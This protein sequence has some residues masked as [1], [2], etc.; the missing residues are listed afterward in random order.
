MRET[1][2]RKG[3][4]ESS[5]RAPSRL[6]RP[7]EN[8][9][10]K[11]LIFPSRTIIHDDERIVERAFHHDSWR[12]KDRRTRLPLYYYELIISLTEKI[13]AL[14]FLDLMTHDSVFIIGPEI[15]TFSLRPREETIHLVLIQIHQTAVLFTIL[16][17]HIV[18]THITIAHSLFLPR[19]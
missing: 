13:Y 1:F 2:I 9:S 18:D 11:H 8:I 6:Y 19:T 10:R 15:W 16:I 7:A 14:F 12:W 3:T 17:I 4:H 5:S